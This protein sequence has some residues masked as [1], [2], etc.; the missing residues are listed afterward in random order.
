MTEE[1]LGVEHVDTLSA[2]SSLASAYGCQGRYRESEELCLQVLK[3]RKKALGVEH[4]M[5]QTVTLLYI[6]LPTTHY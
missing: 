2:M 1:A 3:G 4:G 6:Q 5:V